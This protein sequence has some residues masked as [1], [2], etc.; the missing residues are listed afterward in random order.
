MQ[1]YGGIFAMQ[2]Y[3]NHTS[4]WMIS[5]KFAAFLQNTFCEE[6]LWRAAS[7]NLNYNKKRAVSCFLSL[8]SVIIHQ[9]HSYA[10]SL[11]LTP[12]IPTPSSP[13][14]HLDSPHSH[15][16]SHHSHPDFHH[17]HPDSPHSHPD[18][19][20]SPPWFPALTSWFPAFP[21]LYPAF[22][23]WFSAFP[24]WFPAFPSFP[25]FCS[26]IPHSGFYR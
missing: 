20:H 2:L 10:K 14:F 7:G 9:F 13:H 25:S 26:P 24:P 12:F 15:P 1:I 5:S 3:W 8:S 11:T 18:S 4:A 6:Y 22:L 23:L 17:C 19:H 21:P 16:N